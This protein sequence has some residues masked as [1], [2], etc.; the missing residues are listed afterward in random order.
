[1]NISQYIN[2]SMRMNI[3]DKFDP[4]CLCIYPDYNIFIGL[5]LLLSISFLFNIM[6]EPFKTERFRNKFIDT[7]SF[8]IYALIMMITI[9]LYFFIYNFFFEKIGYL[10]GYI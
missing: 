6:F 3:T 9:N 7:K 8:N 2:I 10:L 5:N 1:M 4:Q